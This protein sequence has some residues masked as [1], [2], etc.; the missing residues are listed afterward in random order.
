MF[1]DP[2]GNGAL[3]PMF[4]LNGSLPLTA[5]ESENIALGF[6]FRPGVAAWLRAERELLRHRLHR[7]HPVDAVRLRRSDAARTSGNSSASFRTMR[8]PPAYLDAR[9][10]GGWFFIDWEEIGSTGVRY[11][12]DLRQ[13][14][15]ARTQLSG[16]DATVL[17]KFQLD[18][19][20]FDL[21]LNVT[22]LNEILTS[23]DHDTTTFDMVD[24]FN[25]PLDWRFHWMGTW[26]RGGLSTSVVAELCGHRTSTTAW[27][28]MH[29]SARGP[30]RI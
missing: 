29:R 28:S 16:F 1:D 26:I 27:R 19:N 17:Y 4:Y 12:Y 30:R 9:S 6:T 14:N 22:H 2:S 8:L 23:L 5:E 20:A 24:T 7:S 18:Q 15:A 11:L 10:A 21:Q 13:Q 25:Q 3:I